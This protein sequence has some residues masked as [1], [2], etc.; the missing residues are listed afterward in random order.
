MA[1]RTQGA[2]VASTLSRKPVKLS[3]QVGIEI[4][5]HA[6]RVRAAAVRVKRGCAAENICG[7]PDLDHLALYL[8]PPLPGGL[9]VP[10][11]LFRMRIM[12][13]MR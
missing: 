1:S 6:T 4:Y 9:L 10:Q 5:F 2:R 13:L 3:L 12:S 8:P 7:I 11:R